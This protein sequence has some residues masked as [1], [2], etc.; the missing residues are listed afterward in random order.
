MWLRTLGTDGKVR[1]A[2]AGNPTATYEIQYDV[3]VR[4]HHLEGT[5]AVTGIRKEFG[6]LTRAVWDLLPLYNPF[7]FRVRNTRCQQELL[8]RVGQLSG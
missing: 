8:E 7:R 3:G 5:L 4:N 2:W 6:P 1:L